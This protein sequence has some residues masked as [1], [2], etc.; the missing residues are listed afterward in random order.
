MSC[1]ILVVKG[2]PQG[3]RMKLMKKKNIKKL[4]SILCVTAMVTAL[5][6]G[7]SKAETKEVTA[8]SA[9][10]G[11]VA[12]ATATRVS[13]IIDEND[14][15][16][17]KD[18]DPSYT[19]SEAST[20]TL[21]DSASTSD[22]SFVTIDGD[23]ITITAEGIYEI[24]GSLSNGQIIVDV[25]D[26]NAKVQLV[27]DG[28]DI[29]CE[30]SAAVYVK[31]ADK[32]FITLADGSKNTLSNS[33][34]F[35]QTDDNNVNAVIYSRD[36]LTLN[37]SGS[38][39]VNAKYGHAISSK[40]DLKLCGGT[41]VINADE[42]NGL[43]ANDSVR[44]TSSNIT[45][46]SVNDAI[47]ADNDEDE[48]Q[49]FV[50]IKDGT[51]TINAEDDGI[52]ASAAILI[53]DGTVD[54]QKSTEGVE[55]RMIEVQGGTVDVVASDDGFNAS[56]G[57][58]TTSTT[59]TTDQTAVSTNSTETEV[60]ETAYGAERPDMSSEMP[61]GEA[62][63]GNMQQGDMAGGGMMDT[64]SSCYLLI[65]GGV[66]TVNADGDGLDS[67]GYMYIAGGYTVVYGPTNSGNGALDSGVSIEVSG[68]T[69]IALGASGMAEGFSDSSTQG[70]ILCNSVSGSKGDTVTLTDSNGN[71]IISIES[72]KSFGSVAIS[73][74][75][76]TQGS[77]YTISAGSTSADIEMSSL[78]YTDSQGNMMGGGMQGGRG[79]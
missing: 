30:T 66:V 5:F 20:I 73:T 23:T 16:S 76:I 15:F 51:V 37:G 57:S 61:S 17:D 28:V 10:A 46:T 50:Y 69:V 4:L 68:G 11:T 2:K 18:L 7:C 27:F 54:I 63:S 43:D 79:F 24:S 67:N 38:L 55:A 12:V 52:H 13:D 1:I 9:D 65:S 14:M 60:I 22:S 70:A 77:T 75:D 45:I 6:F 71:E 34:D 32:V 49:G 33:S 25:A 74:P 62:P 21:K 41:Y 78:V 40:D 8:V 35:V 59:T 31:Q 47:H 44:I 36:D 19:A 26:E 53:K 72:L 58:S 39:T 56:S 3:E 48:T 42:K 64:D 29:N